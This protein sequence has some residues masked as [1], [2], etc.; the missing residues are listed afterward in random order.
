MGWCVIVNPARQVECPVP[1]LISVSRQG[2]REGTTAGGLVR[3]AHPVYGGSSLSG[4]GTR[5]QGECREKESEAGQ[6]GKK[7]KFVRGKTNH[8]VT[9]P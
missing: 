4:F 5:M 9:G 8:R 1:E 7:R 3:G 6:S 2:P